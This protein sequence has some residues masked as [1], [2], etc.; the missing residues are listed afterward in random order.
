MQRLLTIISPYLLRREKKILMPSDDPTTTTATSAA[1]SGLTLSA[2]K[3]D[4]VVWTYL[5]PVQLE[6][7]RTYLKSDAVKDVLE[8]NMSP[9]EI[10][11]ALKKLCD[12]ALLQH[13]GDSF[14][15]HF[16]EYASELRTKQYPL[17]LFI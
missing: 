13:T 11:T 17:L 5:S 2:R 8:F 3:N 14:H 6:L 15:E 7:Y 16:S 12:H 4:F 9:L 1:D 10:L